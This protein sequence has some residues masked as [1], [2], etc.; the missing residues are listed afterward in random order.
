MTTT[1]A[2]HVANDSKKVA[3][4][5]KKRKLCIK[6]IGIEIWGIQYTSNPILGSLT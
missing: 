5:N 3:N 4:D 1:S 2:Q 6:S